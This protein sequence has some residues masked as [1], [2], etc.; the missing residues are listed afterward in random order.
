MS[1]AEDCRVAIIG[2]GPGGLAAAMLLGHRGAEVT[3]FESRNEEG[4]RSGAFRGTTQ[5]GIFSFDIGPT[6]FLYPEMLRSLFA[7]CGLDLDR[8]V[9]LARLDHHYDLIFEDGPKLSV[10]SRVDDLEAEI[11]KIS[12]TDAVGVRP[13]LTENRRKLEAFAPILQRPFNSL[14]DVARLDMLKALPLLRPHRSVDADLAR[15][16]NDPRTRLAFSFQSKYLGMSPYRCPSLF[17][18]LGF[19]EHEFGVHHPI[20]GT[21]AVMAAM[22]RA[23]E[24]FGVRF[25]MGEAVSQIAF[26]GRRAVGVVTANGVHPADAVVVNADFG[27][28]MTRLVPDRLRRRWTDRKITGKR[29]SCS[30]FM[31]YL[32]IEGRLDT[33][34]HHSIFLSREYQK[35]FAEVEAGLTLP[36]DP[37][38][39]VQNACVTD[40]GLAPAGFSTLYVLMPVGHLREDG[41]DWSEETRARARALVLARLRD[42]GFPDLEHRIRFE[43]IVTPQDWED[44]MDVHRGAVF[45]LAH[46]LDQM[47][48]LRPHNRFEDLERVY[49]VGGGTHPGSGLPVIFSGARVSCALLADDLGLAKAPRASNSFV[50]PAGA[51]QHG[52][53]I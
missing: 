50:A 2:S 36:Q 51:F 19:M 9:S 48:Y 41:L 14:A 44:E 28:A 4:G 52:E 12:A 35:N 46:S 5:D 23:A 53:P 25:R 6:F 45:N 1:D 18:I 29:Y 43:K 24:R 13:F 42:A 39:Y 38:L 30:T 16:F 31:L 10:S 37:S 27:R 40:P 26:S 7:E 3:V 17:T 49:L 15:Y 33:I 47:L 21:R 8:E 32:G 20:G 11:A 22:R 34:G